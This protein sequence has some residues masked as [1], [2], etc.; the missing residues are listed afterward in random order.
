MKPA[1]QIPIVLVAFLFL[2]ACA[3]LEQNTKRTLGTTAY[4]VDA[5]M[6]GFGDYVRAGKA[7]TAQESFVRDMYGQYQRTMAIAE[8]AVRAYYK[9]T[10]TDNQPATADDK[11][12]LKQVARSLSAASGDLITFITEIIH[13]KK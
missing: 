1:L 5:A 6:N 8:K 2:T 3:N 9:K 11:Q 13:G 12:Q 10:V 4:A 7:T